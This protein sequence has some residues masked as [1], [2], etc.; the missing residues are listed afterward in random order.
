MKRRKIIMP[1]C[2]ICGKFVK[3]D[4]SLLYT[5]IPDTEYSEEEDM[6]THKKC[7]LVKKGYNEGKL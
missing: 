4:K 2:S 3:I 1:R 5:Y 7:F 6:W